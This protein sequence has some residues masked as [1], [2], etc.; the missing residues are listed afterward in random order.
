MKRDADV[1]GG[2]SRCSDDVGRKATDPASTAPLRVDR[3]RRQTGL[4]P[5]TDRHRQL[6]TGA[7][8]DH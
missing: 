7:R 4:Q 2:V 8:T 6:R 1:G 5:V 3:R